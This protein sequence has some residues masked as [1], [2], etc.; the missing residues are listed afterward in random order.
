MPIRNISEIFSADPKSAAD[1]M[2]ERSQGFFIPGYQRQYAWERVHILQLIED[3]AHGVEQLIEQDNA[4]TFIGTLITIRDTSNH[5]VDESAR[6]QL[7]GRVMTVIDGQQRL[8]TLMLVNMVLHDEINSRNHRFNKEDDAASLWI[9]HQC[10]HTLA[11]LFDTLED[12]MSSSFGNENLRWYPRMIREYTDQWSRRDS[13][14]KYESPIAHMLHAYGTHVRS[15]DVQAFSVNR[16]NSVARSFNIVRRTIRSAIARAS[17]ATIRLPLIEQLATEATLSVA[18]FNEPLPEPVVA[19]LSNS[20]ASRYHELFRLLVFSRFILHHVVVTVVTAKSE[21]YAFDMFES[22][23]TT[24]E[25]LTAFETFKPQ[26]IGVEGQADYQDSQ[27]KRLI[28]RVED[29]LASSTGAQRRQ[30]ATHALLLAFALA[31]SG[32]RLYKRPSVQRNYLRNRYTSL[33][34]VQKV[35]FV[36]QMAHTALFMQHASDR[37]TMDDDGPTLSGLASLGTVEKLC[38]DVLSKGNHT[39]TVGPLARF[40]SAQRDGDDV[41]I[42]EAAKAMAAFYG[43][44]RAAHGGTAG[45]DDL[46]RSLMSEGD[47]ELGIAPFARFPIDHGISDPP[48]ADDLRRYFRTCLQREGL[49]SREAWVAKAKQTP[50]YDESRDATRLLLLAAMHDTVADSDH[51]GL[52]KAARG[53]VLRLLTYEQWSNQEN[54]TIEHIAPQH[55]DE[56]SEWPANLYEERETIHQIGNLLLLPSSDN[57]SISDRPWPEKRAIYRVLAA[58]TPDEVEGEIAAAEEQGIEIPSAIRHRTE[59]LPLTASVA[60]Y[61]DDWDLSIVNRRST[62]LLE[63]AWDRLV[64]WI[65]L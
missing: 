25:P 28:D 63:L 16:D 55:Y 29:Y 39:I 60:R 3:V 47:P 52:V 42:A 45:I 58:M 20:D 34:E 62:R 19:K 57:S 4:T 40:Y 10:L 43:L 50:I 44:W 14:A 32:R 24:G 33:E 1:F 53:N 59:Y 5:S 26:V 49:G 13:Q 21:D 17:N 46:Y 54:I 9:Y 38:L 27:L 2:R 6:G 18:L 11:E 35:Y 31:E 15:G 65:G 37:D 64:P 36:K 8:T 51:P 30:Q 7:P 23:N 56:G 41:S 48:K 12:D 61:E 22:L